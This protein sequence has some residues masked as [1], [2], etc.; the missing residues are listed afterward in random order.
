MKYLLY[1]L[2]WYLAR[3]I[4]FKNPVHIDLEVS[5]KCPLQCDF[6]FRQETKIIPKNITKELIDIVLN[7]AKCKSMKFNWRGESLS[8]NR[9]YYA[10]RMAKVKDI[11]TMLNTSL[12]IP[13]DDME[14]VAYNVDEIKVSFDS[15]ILEIYEQI[16]KGGN[17]DQIVKRIFL[18]RYYRNEH[19]KKPLVISRRTVKISEPDAAFKKYFEGF[20]TDIRPAIPRNESK[21]Y[22]YQMSKG[23]KYCGQPSRR[24]VIDVNGNC[25]AC[26]CAYKEPKEL[27]LGNVHET[28]IENIWNGYKRLKIVKQLKKGI[29]NKAC[30]ECVSKEAF[31]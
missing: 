14:K 20:K 29:L 27:Y 19:N 21:I 3:W 30:A 6:C 7:Q 17:F 13:V 28:S 31:I 2:K 11:W 23:R 16:R 26:C 22:D 8:T 24:V 4:N 1:R 10:L 15:S 12:C 5:T 18:L 9:L 25:W